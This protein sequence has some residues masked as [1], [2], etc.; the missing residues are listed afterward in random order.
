MVW[1][2]HMTEEQA[3]WDCPNG[4]HYSYDGENL[5]PVCEFIKG[6]SQKIKLKKNNEVSQ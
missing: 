2:I 6:K 4:T 5:H 3:W 1:N